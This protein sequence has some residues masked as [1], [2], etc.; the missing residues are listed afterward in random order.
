MAADRGTHTPLL[1]SLSARLLVL[2]I[3][4]VMLSEVLIYAPSVARYRHVY[5]EDRLSAGH[6]A[7]L[8]LEAT[9]DHMIDEALEA[10][11]LR[12]S[13]AH[14][15]RLRK[16]GRSVLLLGGS[17]P[18]AVDLTVDLREQGFLQLIAD[19]FAAMVRTDNRVLRVIGTSPRYPEIGVEVVIDEAPMRAAMHDFSERILVLSLLISLITASLVYLSLQWLMVRPMRRITDSMVT[20]RQAP[21]DAANVVGTSDRTDEIG[22]AFRELAMMQADLRAALWQ[23]TRLAALG[24]A[25]TKI[26]HDL[27]G[28]LSTALVVSDRLENSAD[29][30]VRRVTP[31]LV[32]AIDRAVDLC[33]Q[34]LG[35]A[36]EG[37]PALALARFPLAG[38]I[39]ES[40]AAVRAPAV[41][42]VTEGPPGLAVEADR[43]QLFRVLFNLLRNAV[44]AG[45]RTIR[46]AVENGHEGVS[47]RVRDD[48][49][50]IPEMLRETLFQPFAGSGKTDGSGLGLVI[51]RDLMR[52]HGGDIELVTTGPDGTEFA[53]H[54]PPARAADPD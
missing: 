1:S 7:T 54:L 5:L 19:A 3:G 2:T 47:I 28:I 35:Y 6:L 21:E 26:N 48:G 50:G 14:L 11:L 41:R 36:Q 44:Q 20:F 24:Q 34:T 27:R 15:V 23:K 40:C 37:P 49:S 45:A 43:D 13:M 16:P 8:A 51:A 38:L 42:F 12:H 4:F 18:P 17:M 46:I 22:V 53:L 10:E 9:P 29:P 30:E 32:S 52:A 33:R 25:V 39:D 31:A